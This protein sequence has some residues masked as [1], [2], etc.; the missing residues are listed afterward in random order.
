MI[1]YN[2]RNIIKYLKFVP[3]IQLL[4]LMCRAQLSCRIDMTVMIFTCLCSDN[5]NDIIMFSVKC[6]LV[7]IYNA[8][9]NE[10]RV[11]IYTRKLEIFGT[12]D[13]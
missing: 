10:I 6:A 3:H 8:I 9:Y 5:S 1:L 11:G 4:Q 13:N 12:F 7:G 2:V